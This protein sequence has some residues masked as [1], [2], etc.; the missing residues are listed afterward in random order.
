MDFPSVFWNPKIFDSGTAERFVDLVHCLTSM[1]R[2]LRTHNEELRV[3]SVEKLRPSGFEAV[4]I[5]RGLPG[6]TR[7]STFSF[8]TSVDGFY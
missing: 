7:S 3:Y 5:Y 4:K 2:N 1:A 8:V 6:E